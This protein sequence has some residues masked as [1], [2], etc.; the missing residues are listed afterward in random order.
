MFWS[1]AI[2]NRKNLINSADGEPLHG[3]DAGNATTGEKGM[4]FSWKFFVRMAIG[5]IASAGSYFV[6]KDSNEVGQDDLIG[7]T[8]LYVA[9][10][11]NALV[12]DKPAPKAPEF[13]R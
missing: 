9:D 8:L 13:L 5:P 12:I 4:E 2:L 10:I 6:N 7:K 3:D 1:A 11:L